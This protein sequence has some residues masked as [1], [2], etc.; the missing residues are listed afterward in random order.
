MRWRG[1]AACCSLE[2]FFEANI[3]FI[4]VNFVIQ[5]HERFL[6]FDS[7]LVKLIHLLLDI[8]SVIIHL[9]DQFPEHFIYSLAFVKHKL[10]QV[11][12]LVV[13]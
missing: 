12:R 8:A 11:L 1:S 13:V 6:V 2:E 5:K 7:F 9:H 4:F 10:I 3:V